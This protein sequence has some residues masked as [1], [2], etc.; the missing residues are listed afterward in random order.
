MSIE[1]E[2]Q[3]IYLLKSINNGSKEVMDQ[4][5]HAERRL[6]HLE[7]DITRRREKKSF[8]R[9]IEQE[10]G[11]EK[12]SMFLQQHGLSH[13]THLFKHTTLRDFRRADPVDWP[14][15]SESDLRKLLFLR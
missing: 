6:R 15:M 1:Q 14:P 3:L 12:L 7:R 2:A 13:L 8:V 10:V 4:L 5:E 9:R 11:E